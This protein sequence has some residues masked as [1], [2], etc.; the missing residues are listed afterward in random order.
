MEHSAVSTSASPDAASCLAIL[1]TPERLRPLKD[2]P[3][4]LKGLYALS[5]CHGRLRYIGMTAQDDF[6]QRINSRHVTGSEGNSHKFSCAYNVGRL[7]RGDEKRHPQQ[8]PSD[9]AIAKKLRTAFVRHFCKA[10]WV[11]LE[12][13][14]VDLGRL[15]TAVI[16]LAPSSMKDW[17]G[18]RVL[19]EPEPTDLLDAFLDKQAWPASQIAAIERQAS[20]FCAEVVRIVS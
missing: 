5:D 20:L 4:G 14:P 12:V 3:R 9:A 18:T 8:I 2:A 15:E 13:D 10:A 19:A 16:A 17:N 11:P 1:C 7:W 6:R